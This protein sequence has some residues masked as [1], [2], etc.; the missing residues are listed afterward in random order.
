M[1]KN[2]VYGMHLLQNKEVKRFTISSIGNS[3]KIL[4]FERVLILL[5]R[6]RGFLGKMKNS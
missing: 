3:N 4:I 6:I 5:G 2:E 1:S